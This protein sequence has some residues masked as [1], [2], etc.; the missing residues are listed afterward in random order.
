MKKGVIFLVLLIFFISIVSAE[1]IKINDLF[2]MDPSDGYL[3]DDERD[4]TSYFYAGEKL[5]AV[6]EGPIKYNYQ[7]RL[8]SNRLDSS[9]NEYKLLPFGQQLITGGQRFSFTG[10]EYDE[11][12]KLYD[13]SARYYDAEAGKFISVDPV[14]ENQAYAYV[15]NNPM[16][17]IDPTGM[18][19]DYVEPYGSANYPL[20]YAR[21]LNGLEGLALRRYPIGLGPGLT[22]G[23]RG[24]FAGGNMFNTK[25][26][27]LVGSG[28]FGTEP[29][30][31][32]GFG[33]SQEYSRTFPVYDSADITVTGRLSIENGQWSVSGRGYRI[34]GGYSEDFN[35]LGDRGLFAIVGS[36][37]GYTNFKSD[38]IVTGDIHG[39]GGISL[40]YGGIPILEESIEGRQSFEAGVNTD[41]SMLTLELS[42]G[43]GTQFKM[44]HVYGSIGELFSLVFEGTT[45]QVSGG[46]LL[47]YSSGGLDSSVSI[48]G[49]TLP[50]NLRLGERIDEFNLGYWARFDFGSAFATLRRGVNDEV[51]FGTRI[52]F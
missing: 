14:K 15:G 4:T 28:L 6:K 7:D 51:R 43:L 18:E 41:V 17:L 39:E 1:T 11:E 24:F 47:Q 23:W 50:E 12:S 3:P 9:G 8:G 52:G 2:R 19:E 16:N 37:I 33:G 21:D 40:N 30:F 46:P 44:P 48:M 29:S 45:V 32:N 25:D 27:L 13:F 36:S 35:L 22:V 49:Y 42:P 5:I 34:Y 38:A 31:G 10:K 20:D 26:A